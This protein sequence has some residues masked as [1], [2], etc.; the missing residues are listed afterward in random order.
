M[1]SVQQLKSRIRSV[2]STK[3]I[4]KAMQLVAASK[5]RRSTSAVKET[6]DYAT[7]ARELLADLAHDRETID[8]HPMFQSRPV[9]RRLLIA[10]SSDT[11]LAGAYNSNI[12]KGLVSEL[13]NDNAQHVHTETLTLGRKVSQFTS[14]LKEVTVIGSYEKL[15]DHPTGLEIKA[16]LNE[17]IDRFIGLK[18]DAVDLIFTRFHS[19]INQEVVVERLLPAGLASQSDYEQVSDEI[20]ES[21][22]EPSRDEVLD[23]VTERLIE[24]QI[25][26]ALL[27]SRAS[28]HSMRMMAM[29]NATDNASSLSS[30]LTL[31]MNKERQA[32]IT[33]EL[34]EISGGVEAVV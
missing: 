25:V 34:A 30:D 21:R 3:Q 29:K 11:G 10:I 16:I 19:P 20:R 27:D 12:L 14:R 32:A 5:M 31:A 33:Q 23:A 22:F 4:T 26:Q 6:A 28:E 7:A 17:A 8:S 13:K 9:K 1:A 2:N 24:T 18:C 15:P